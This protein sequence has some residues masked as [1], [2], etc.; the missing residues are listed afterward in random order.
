MVVVRTL[1]RLGVAVLIV[2]GSV[3]PILGA[4]QPGIAASASVSFQ[5]KPCDH[6]FACDQ[7]CVVQAA[8]SGAC[9]P[10]GLP[11]I[12]TQAPIVGVESLTPTASSHV[13]SV[14]QQIPTPPPRLRVLV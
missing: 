13:S 14:G 12:N 5:A 7:A 8:C 11:E 9:L 10:F 2:L 1:V 6:C 3:V 4:V